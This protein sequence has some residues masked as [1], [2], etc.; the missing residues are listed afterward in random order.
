MSRD[1]VRREESSGMCVWWRRAVGRECNLERDDAL[2]WCDVCGDYVV[3]EGY[4][5]G[6]WTAKVG[7]S[8]RGMGWRIET[9]LAS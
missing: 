7:V 3:V 8:M 4:D 1:D 9:H 5:A 2:A 6:E